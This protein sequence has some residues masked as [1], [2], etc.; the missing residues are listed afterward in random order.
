M[1]VLRKLFG[2]PVVTLTG[3]LASGTWI[4]VCVCHHI[5]SQGCSSRILFSRCF[6]GPRLES[7]RAFHKTGLGMPGQGRIACMGFIIRWDTGEVC[8][9]PRLR[10]QSWI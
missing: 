6:R 5:A 1:S 3:V 7:C 2:L 8:V 9:C 4:R 10:K